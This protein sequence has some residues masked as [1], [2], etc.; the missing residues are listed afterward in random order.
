ME[1]VAERNA[2]RSKFRTPDIADFRDGNHWLFLL[3]GADQ[4]LSGFFDPTE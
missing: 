1:R 3:R 4:Y 2:A